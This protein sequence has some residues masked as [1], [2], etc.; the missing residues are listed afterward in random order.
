VNFL[1][2]D[3]AVTVVKLHADGHETTRYPGNVISVGEQGDWVVIEARWTIG[4]IVAGGL[5]FEVGDKLLEWFSPTHWFNVFHVYAP[6]GESRGWYANVTYPTTLEYGADAPIVTWH[7]LYLDLITPSGTPPTI[8]DADELEASGLA[9]TDP[10]LH[11]RILASM[12]E[13]QSFV[14]QGSGPFAEIEVR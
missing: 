7:D 14:Q 1:H 11:A 13:L 10:E 2:P 12:D 5:V 6:S 9:E 8:Y 4:R 3:D